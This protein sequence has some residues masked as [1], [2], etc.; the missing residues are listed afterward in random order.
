MA[1]MLIERSLFFLNIVNS[2]EKPSGLLNVKSWSTGVAKPKPHA[3]RVCSLTSGPGTKDLSSITG[4]HS[5]ATSISSAT[6]HTSST[7]MTSCELRLESK[8]TLFRASG[9]LVDGKGKLENVQSVL[10]KQGS[11]AV[12]VTIIAADTCS[13]LSVLLPDCSQN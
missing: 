6:T 12:C 1:L 5:H 11:N 13:H 9:G 4:P 7:P 8:T 3:T 2:T 10:G